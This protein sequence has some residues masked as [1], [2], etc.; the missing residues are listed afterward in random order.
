[1]ALDRLLALAFAPLVL[2]LGTYLLWPS[3]DWFNYG[4]RCWSDGG[5]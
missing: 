2:A 1:M 5:L 4:W 3:I